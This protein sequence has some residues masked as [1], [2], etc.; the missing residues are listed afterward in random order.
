MID[1]DLKQVLFLDI[2]TVPEYS[3]FNLL[4]EEK[5]ELWDKKTDKVKY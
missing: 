4:N 1:I 3:D 5:Q 2:E